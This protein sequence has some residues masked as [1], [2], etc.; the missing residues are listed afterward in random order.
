MN[1]YILYILLKYILY[2]YIYIFIWI[3]C[4]YF[5]YFF[6]NWKLPSW[7]NLPSWYP[8]SDQGQL[9]S[10][11][12]ESPFT[13][14]KVSF[15]SPTLNLLLPGSHIFLHLYLLACL[16]K[17]PR[18]FS[19]FDEKWFMKV[20]FSWPWSIFK[21]LYF[22]FISCGSLAACRIFVE[23]VPSESSRHE[24]FLLP[25]LLNSIRIHALGMCPNYY[26]HAKHNPKC[27]KIMISSQ[28]CQDIKI[29]SYL[30]DTTGSEIWE[31]HCRDSS[32][33]C[34]ENQGLS[35]EDFRGSRVSLQRDSHHLHVASHMSPAPGQDCW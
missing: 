27:T 1:I 19:S 6:F 21:T 7:R 33:L 24:S 31:G 34:H 17:Y 22:F 13:T 23:S 14:Q 20:N 8:T 32:S 28:I 10:Y 16:M 9:Q 12:L 2:I 26:C 18:R 35:W 4:T 5:I 25:V 15:D 11:I 30:A 29:S 3:Y